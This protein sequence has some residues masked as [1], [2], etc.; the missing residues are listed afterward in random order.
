M[1]RPFTRAQALQNAAFLDRLALSGN[2]RLAAREIGMAHSTLH[3]RRAKHA[4]FAQA[5]EAVLAA[6]HARVDLAGG[7]RGPEA[8]RGCRRAG[9]KMDSG[10][11]RNDGRGL[12]TVGGEPMVVRTRSGR[13]QLRMAHRNKLTRA[14]EEAF[15]DALLDTAN[16]RFS[17]AAAGASARA[18]YRRRRRKP[19]FA[20]EVAQSIVSAQPRIERAGREATEQAAREAARAVDEG[21]AWPRGLTVAGALRALGRPP[22]KLPARRSRRRGR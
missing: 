11:R 18:F 7:Q 3:D 19:A 9:E 16:I 14:A 15:L 22:L 10:L 4:G 6:A 2:S 8:E 1:P 12:R 13:L 20:A 5:W 17:A 21:P